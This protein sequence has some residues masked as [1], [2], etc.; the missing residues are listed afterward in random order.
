SCF[1]CVSII[2]FAGAGLGISNYLSARYFQPDYAFGQLLM[3]LGFLAIAIIVGI[4]RVRS[5]YGK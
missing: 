5:E 3:G 2:F 1:W 4:I